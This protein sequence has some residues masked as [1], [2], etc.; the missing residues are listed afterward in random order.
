MA[1]LSLIA[2]LGVD[3]SP[4]RRGLDEASN[5][6]SSFANKNSNEIKSKLAGAFK[7][8]A[9]ALTVGSIFEWA[10]KSIARLKTKA[11]EANINALLLG[12]DP[13]TAQRIA[14]AAEL[15]DTST[16]AIQHALEKIQELKDKVKEAT[17]ETEKLAKSIAQFGINGADLKTKSPKE[18]FDKMGASLK[19]TRVE[20]ERLAALRDVLGRS[21]PGLIPFFNMDL[22]SAEFNSGNLSEKDI[23]LGLDVKEAEANAMAPF[24]E[25]EK[26]TD[27]DFA[28]KE[29]MAL[30]MLFPKKGGLK[31]PTPNT[32]AAE[33]LAGLGQDARDRAATKLDEH[34][35]AKEISTQMERLSDILEKNRLNNLNP[36]ARLADLIAGRTKTDSYTPTLSLEQKIKDAEREGEIGQLARARKDVRFKSDSLADIGGFVGNAAAFNPAIDIAR[37][38]LGKLSQIEQHTNPGGKPHAFFSAS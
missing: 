4:F 36:E 26:N 12:T 22:N 11:K 31:K 16:G 19:G 5:A 10:E 27:V 35:P 1:F 38:Q 6:A 23:Q 17:P 30:N 37:Q 33:A 9:A 25:F 13:V 32:S 7:A 29:A 3:I 20:G 8:G 2:K 21:G 15:T 18:I 24:K 28:E 34:G 14:K